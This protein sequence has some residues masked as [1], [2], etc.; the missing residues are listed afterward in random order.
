MEQQHINLYSCNSVKTKGDEAMI[1]VTNRIPLKLGAGDM[2]A[3]NFT[4]PG[5]LQ[6]L[7]G[8]IKVEVAKTL[9]LPEYDELEVRTYWRDMESFDAWKN[10]DAFHEAHQRPE[11]GTNDNP[12]ESPII[13]S[14]L[15][16]SEVLSVLGSENAER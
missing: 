16:I 11:S 8:F 14:K 3:P 6:S 1:I 7:D 15:R 4:R 13:E 12:G 5:K 2:M 9:K 10:S